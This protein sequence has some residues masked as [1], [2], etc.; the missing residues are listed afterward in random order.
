MPKS[1]EDFIR[2]QDSIEKVLFWVSLTVVA[3]AALVSFFS[4]LIENL[5][6]KTV[7]FCAA[8]FVS[9]LLIGLFAQ[10]TK[11]ISVSY[12]ILCLWMCTAILPLQFFLY[13]GLN[14]SLIIYFF[15]S[16]FLCALHSNKKRR[17]L[18]VAY[19]IFASEVTLIL[20][21]LHPELVA[22]V[23]PKATFIDYCVTYLLL[24]VAL[25][26]TTSYLLSLYSETQK[27]REELI[28]Q[29]QYFA[30]KDPLTDLY[31]RRYFISNLTNNVWLIR[32][33]FYVYM[34]DI[35]N[36]KKINDT[37][38]HPFG[39]E[40]LRKVGEIAHAFENRE[41]GE[42]A[43][44]Y[45][46]EEF[47]QLIRAN[48]MEEAFAKTETIRKLVSTIHFDGKPEMKISISGGLVD[49]ASE[50]FEGQNK[51]LSGVDALLYKAKSQGKNQTCYN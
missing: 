11:K 36:F 33:N 23:D 10:L 9:V 24:S 5:P 40:V 16:I 4:S 26:A 50:Q 38:G 18:M 20:S 8:S 3:L 34:Y 42:L 19:A 30:E 31:N 14:S 15:G 35:D 37:Y 45:G 12:M 1:F 48:S 13:G 44:R 46:G 47:I 41:N 6:A 32:K 29:L 2:K 43:V 25:A 17:F 7:A 51:M 27:N 21:W 22:E 28:S 49:C 39:D